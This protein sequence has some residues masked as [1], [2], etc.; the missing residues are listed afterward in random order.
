MSISEKL[1]SILDS[2]NAIGAAIINKGQELSIATPFSDWAAK[3]DAIES[4][5]VINGATIVTGVAAEDMLKGDTAVRL[6]RQDFPYGMDPVNSPVAGLF[7]ATEVAVSPDGTYIAMGGMYEPYI[8]LL[9]RQVDGS[10]AAL[11]PQPITLPYLTSGFCFNPDDSCLVIV[12]GNSTPSVP[13]VLVYNYDKVTDVF[14][15]ILA[16]N[17]PYTSPLGVSFT[18]QG[19]L[20]A[21]VYQSST[22]SVYQRAGNTYG[23]VKNIGSVNVRNMMCAFSPDGNWFAV[24]GY[25][26]SPRITLFSRVG[27]VFTKVTTQPTR[28]SDSSDIVFSPNSEYMAIGGNTSPYLEVY[29]LIDSVWTLIF[30]D[31]TYSAKRVHFTADGR[32]LVTVRGSATATLVVYSI[33][34]STITN[35][36]QTGVCNADWMSFSG[37][38]KVLAIASSVTAPYLFVYDIGAFIV[39]SKLGNE[40]PYLGNVADVGFINEDVLK[41][42]TAEMT[43][44]IRNPS[45]Y[46]V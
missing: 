45:N 11:V 39:V 28:T 33:S 46:P 17:L 24:A 20:F 31:S 12:I 21:I 8:T 42:A 4:G 10:Y 19:D 26:G 13:R 7:Q 6:F 15:G 22:I 30:S 38:E 9:K 37:S 5:S 3:I 40:L 41:D 27:T 32:Y 18:P 36:A 34:G 2:K 25:Y 35:V 14:T 43:S 1:Q 23:F 16:S 29:R 44:I